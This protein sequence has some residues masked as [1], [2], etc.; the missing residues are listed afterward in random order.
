MNQQALLSDYNR[1]HHSYE[2]TDITSPLFKTIPDRDSGIIYFK[3][4]SYEFR[5][6]GRF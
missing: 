1:N 3:S 5:Y 6:Y 4:V 2:K